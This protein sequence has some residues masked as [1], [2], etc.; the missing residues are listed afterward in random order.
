[1]LVS[2]SGLSITVNGMIRLTL[3]LS[4]ESLRTWDSSSRVAFG[5]EL[6]GGRAWQGEIRRA[7]VKTPTHTIDYVRPGGLVVPKSY[8]NI[9]EHWQPSPL[10]LED[11]A[12]DLL[13]AV[14]FIPVGVLFVRLRRPPL[15]VAGATL[16]AMVLSLSLLLGKLLFNDRHLAT[17]DLVAETVGALVG[18]TAA[19]C[20][21]ERQRRRNR[22]LSAG[23]LAAGRTGS[24]V[25]TASEGSGR[26][27]SSP[28]S[29]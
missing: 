9:F 26:G 10:T 18:A 4:S 2:R 5:D 11:A 13:H 17:A 28:G 3:P 7:V 22:T 15:T 1:M 8:F 25:A 14:A 19:R 16:C 23:P 20:L 12:V 29:K 24:G 6:Y 27:I 21:L